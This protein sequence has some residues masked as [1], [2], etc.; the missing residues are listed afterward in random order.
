M[1]LWRDVACVLRAHRAVSEAMSSSR[2]NPANEE[3]LT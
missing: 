1:P 2:F 3:A